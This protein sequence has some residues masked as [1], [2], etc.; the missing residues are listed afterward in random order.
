MGLGTTTV[1]ELAREVDTA[2]E[3]EAAIVQDVNVESLEVGRGVD[4]ADVSRLHEV[5]GD[6]EVLLV[7]RDL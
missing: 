7:G 1:G 4:D 6:E 2:I 3:T 5:V